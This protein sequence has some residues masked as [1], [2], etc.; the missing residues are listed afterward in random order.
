MGK[1]KELQMELEEITGNPNIMKEIEYRLQKA[2]NNELLV[3]REL[4]KFFIPKMEDKDIEYMQ[5]RLRG[6]KKV[7]FNLAIGDLQ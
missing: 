2:F 7:A 5:G 6:N 1:M 4:Y 3:L